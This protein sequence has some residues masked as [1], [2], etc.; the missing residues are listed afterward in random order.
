MMPVAQLPPRRPGSAAR[1]RRWAPVA[2]SRRLGPSPA[3]LDLCPYRQRSCNTSHASRRFASTLR[4][5]LNSES[6]RPTTSP[7][8]AAAAAARLR[9]AASQ[10][11][12]WPGCSAVPAQSSWR[13]CHS[14]TGPNRARQTPGGSA[15]GA[16]G[17]SFHPP[18]SGTLG[19]TRRSRRSVPG[20]WPARRRAGVYHGG[21]TDGIC[22]T[23]TRQRVKA[24][25][26]PPAGLPFPLPAPTRRR[27]AVSAPTSSGSGAPWPPCCRGCIRL[28][29]FSRSSCPPRPTPGVVRIGAT[30]VRVGNKPFA[31]QAMP[32]VPAAEE[33]GGLA[34]VPLGRISLRWIFTLGIKASR[35]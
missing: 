9:L 7:L 20:L 3:R 14:S 24:D 19:E 27:A 8:A 34:V 23:R 30:R 22:P 25:H 15:W 33:V 32:Q 2:A 31:A 21:R 12:R 26:L 17:A 1:D 11:L 6:R 13:Q 18:W 10:L 28:P 5:A 29:V 16:A 35:V 4:A